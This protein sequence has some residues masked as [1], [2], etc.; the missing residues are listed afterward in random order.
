MPKPIKFMRDLVPT[1]KWWPYATVRLG[2]FVMAYMATVSLSVVF[3]AVAGLTVS[4]GLVIGLVPLAVFAAIRI[5]GACT[6]RWKP[7]EPE[8]IRKFP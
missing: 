6:Q 7:K 2:A 8:M 1:F 4:L 3:F 5:S